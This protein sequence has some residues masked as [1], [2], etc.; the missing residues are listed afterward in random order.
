MD[1][2]TCKKQWKEQRKQKKNKE[3]SENTQHKLRKD[4]FI[5]QL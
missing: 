4:A 2:N 3:I 5:P 1:L